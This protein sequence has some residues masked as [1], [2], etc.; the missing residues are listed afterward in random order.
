M[1]GRAAVAALLL[2]ALG[3]APPVP[4]DEAQATVSLSEPERFYTAG[5]P[6][7]LTLAVFNAGDAPVEAGA[8]LADG[9]RLELVAADGTRL[10]ARP[11]SGPAPG[12]IGPGER[13]RVEL[14]A[15]EIFPG[16]AEPG[17]YLLTVVYPAFRSNTVALKVL[18]AYREDAAYQAVVETDLGTFVLGFFPEVAPGHVR[19]FV[20][21]ARSGF[22][23]GTVVH[24]ILP[25]KMFQAGDPT[26]SGRGGPG[27]TIRG[28]FSERPHRLGTLSMARRADDPNSAGSQ[29]FICLDRVAEWDGLYTVFGEVVEGMET[30]QA[31]GKVPVRDEAPRQPVV[32]RRVAIR[33]AAPAG[34]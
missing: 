31:I 20:N 19:N 16:L 26:G 4:L 13:V 34:A 28:E 3:C 5:S 22:Y 8:G 7:P 23:D 30:V 17:S 29:W 32:I 14:D 9:S 1:R 6:I 2:A 18:P 15:T 24:R 33:E 11:G 10:P 12:R 27:Y 25:G 21:L